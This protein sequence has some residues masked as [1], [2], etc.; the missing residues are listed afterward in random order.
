MKSRLH[1]FCGAPLRRVKAHGGV[2]TVRTRRAER[3][4]LLGIRFVDL[5]IIPPGAS[6][7][8][9][10]HST[11][12]EE[13]YIAVSGEGRISLDGVEHP[14]TT[15]NVAINRRGGQHGLVN[16]GSADLW[17]VVVEVGYE[18]P[19]SGRRRSQSRTRT[20]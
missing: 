15:G 2:G 16:T 1:R 14:F 20:D 7:G 12:N 10:R 17:M 9:H 11:D 13:I 3:G 8:T 6:V 19:T 18:A 4:E 5:T